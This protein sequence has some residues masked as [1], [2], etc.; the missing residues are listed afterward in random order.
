MGSNKLTT[1]EL[2]KNFGFSKQYVKEYF[3]KSISEP[4]EKKKME[5]RIA[6]KIFLKKN[7]CTKPS[8]NKELEKVFRT[9]VLGIDFSNSDKAKG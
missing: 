5:L 2:E 8:F 3:H 9:D 1:K 6:N 7:M 4:G